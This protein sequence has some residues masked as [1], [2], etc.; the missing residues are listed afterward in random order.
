MSKI[1]IL[2]EKALTAFSF[3]DKILEKFEKQTDEARLVLE[4]GRTFDQNELSQ[5]KMD[6]VRP[7]VLY[8][9]KQSSTYQKPVNAE[10][11]QMHGFALSVFRAKSVNGRK[12]YLLQWLGRMPEQALDENPQALAPQ[13]IKTFANYI[14]L[15]QYHKKSMIHRLINQA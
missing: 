14:D 15:K 9:L 7:H 5:E 1:L 4:I 12:N 13:L 8:L 11:A 10:A 2:G 3:D 6:A